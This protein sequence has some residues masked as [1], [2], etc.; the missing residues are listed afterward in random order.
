MALLSMERSVRAWRQARELRGVADEPVR[1]GL[2]KLA[3]MAGEVDRLFPD[4]R[5]FRRPGFDEAP[6]G[7]VAARLH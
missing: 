3:W 6:R 7:R 5:R 2:A 1:A 4:A